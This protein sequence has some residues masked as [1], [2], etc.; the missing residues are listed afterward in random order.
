MEWTYVLNIL[1]MSSRLEVA[2]SPLPHIPQL[3]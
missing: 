2:L 1:I 3:D